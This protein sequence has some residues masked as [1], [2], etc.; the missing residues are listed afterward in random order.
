FRELGDEGHI[1][2]IRLELAELHLQL[3]MTAEAQN[4]ARDAVRV[5]SR[6]GLGKECAQAILH[7]GVAELAEGRPEEAEKA[8]AEARARFVAER[9]AAGPAECDLLR[10]T[11]AVARGD[12]EAA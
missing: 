12:R 2:Q 3:G 7:T 6:A 8:F 5:L 11:A 1:G 4:L 10:A 9:A